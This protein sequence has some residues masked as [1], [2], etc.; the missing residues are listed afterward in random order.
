[1]NVRDWILSK[2][3]RGVHHTPCPCRVEQRV[4]DIQSTATL[5]QLVMETIGLIAQ[6]DVR[7]A[8]NKWTMHI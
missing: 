5:R 1:M 2:H 3:Q 7:P 6:C 4:R 8:A